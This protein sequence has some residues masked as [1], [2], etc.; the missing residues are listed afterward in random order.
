MTYENPDENARAFLAQ[1]DAIKATDVSEARLKT[2]VTEDD[3][4]G[5]AVELLIETG[6][7]IC[8][9]ANLLPK[10][11]HR[12]NRDQ[13]ILGGHL[14]RLYKLLSALLDQICQRRQEIAFIIARIAFECI[15]NLR[16]LIKF[17]N[18][19]EIFDLYVAHSFRQEKRLHDKIQESIDARG[20]Q[21]MPV[22]NRMLNSIAKAMKASAIRI[23]DLSSSRP[24]NWA[25]KTLADRADALGLRD[26]YL[27]AFGGASAAVHGSWMD[28]LEF[29]LDTNHAE[30]NFAPSFQWRNPRPQIGQTV[31]FLA[32]EAARDYF[33]FMGEGP[34]EFM[35][36]KFDEL[37][38]RIRKAA[39]AHDFFLV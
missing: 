34:I 35:D 22:E 1:I 18:D 16:Y 38:S 11:A 32:T 6:S 24:K 37:S 4:N 36:E 28:L 9:A 23:E 5:V 13:A 31:A 3:F 29:Q 8:V 39:Q 17:A 26:A 12:W 7:Y 10:E 33:N 25:D 21:I 15:V 19:P 27:G 2:F 30:A 20:G 14:V